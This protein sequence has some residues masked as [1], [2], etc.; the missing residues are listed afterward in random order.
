M[1]TENNKMDEMFNHFNGQWDNEEPAAGHEDRFLDR[2]DKKKEKKSPKGKGLIYWISIPAAAAIAILLSVVFV[3]SPKEDSELAKISPK[4]EQTQ[5]YFASIINKELEKVQKENT[6]ETKALVEDAMQHMQQMEADYEKITHDLAKNG[7][8]KQLLHA[9]IINLQT[10]I[11]FL[12]DVLVKI[13][14]IKKIKENYH[15]DNKA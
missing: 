14:N 9:M 15:E 10:R 8:N 4:T 2:L 3:F 11:S 5:M 7:E 1:K 12:E 13:E 6:P